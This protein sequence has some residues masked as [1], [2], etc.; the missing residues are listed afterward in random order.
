MSRKR[1]YFNSIASM[2]LGLAAFNFC[3][4]TPIMQVTPAP[5]APVATTVNA[6]PKTRTAKSHSSKH[7][8]HKEPSHETTAHQHETKPT[9][10]K[11]PKKSLATKAKTKSIATNKSKKIKTTT[12][13]KT[14]ATNSRISHSKYYRSSAR[15]LRSAS[16]QVSA[17]NTKRLSSPIK[18]T[19]PNTTNN[20]NQFSTSNISSKANAD[21]ENINTP[22]SSITNTPQITADNSDQANLIAG[23]QIDIASHDDQNRVIP[24]Q[25]NNSQDLAANNFNNELHQRLNLDRTM[26]CETAKAQI[27]TPYQWGKEEPDGGFDCS[28]LIQ[29]VYQQEGITIPRTALEQY[30]SLMPVKHLQEGDLVFFRTD[31][32]SRRVSHVGIY[33]GD[34]YFVD[35]PRTGES[36]RVDRLDNSY[37]ESVYAGARRVLT[38]KKV[39]TQKTPSPELAT[40][41]QNPEALSPTSQGTVAQ[42]SQINTTAAPTQENAIPIQPTPTPINPSTAPTEP[43]SLALDNNSPT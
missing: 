8:A 29:F 11:V 19:Q 1:R 9:T 2:L 22:Q 16:D 15:Q 33:I 6:K 12:K 27:G 32:P 43:N 7:N 41:D 4:A 18:A 10:A 30:H 38:P 5:S 26:A 35:A 3:F 13:P 23:N 42:T 24:I 25:Q 31:P 28:G 21:Q 14:L 39:E 34:G 17:N 20:T 36:V 40:K 37:W